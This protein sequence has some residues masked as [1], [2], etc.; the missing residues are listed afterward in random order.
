MAKT[1][2]KSSERY[3]LEPVLTWVGKKDWLNEHVW[4]AYYRACKERD[5]SLTFV[6]VFAGSAASSHFILPESCWINDSLPHLINFYRYIVK[7][8]KI[9][10]FSNTNEADYYT[11]R[12]RFNEKINTKILNAGGVTSPN[13]YC[14][15]DEMAEL[16]YYLNK[17]GYGGLSRYNSKGEFN[18]PFRGKISNPKTN[19]SAEQEIY[20]NWRITCQDWKDYLDHISVCGFD[21][22]FLLIDPPYY[23]TFNKYTKKDFGWE[24]QVFLA[25]YLATMPN[26]ILATNSSDEKIVELYTDLGF[27]VQFRLRGNMMQ[28]PKVKNG[29][30][31]DFKEAV[32]TKNIKVEAPSD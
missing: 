24:Q 32:F 20:K 5:S 18:V 21:D 4:R 7:Y 10:D 14:Q 12:D 1:K 8:G 22:H 26:P 29:V 30:H 16:F 11:K 6:E 2:S 28:R 13:G 19:F 31:K 25:N 17:A 15:D 23:N 9:P 27:D 3:C